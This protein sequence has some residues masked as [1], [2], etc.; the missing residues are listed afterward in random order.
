M[1]EVNE[2][3]HSITFLT[4]SRTQ[5][6]QQLPMYIAE[7]QGVDPTTD[8]LQYW[9][10]KERTVTISAWFQAF[11]WAAVFQPSSGAV[12]RLFSV[13]D[14]MFTNRQESC[15]ADYKSTSVMMSINERARYFDLIAREEM[16]AE[17]DMRD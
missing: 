10:R 16:D 1:S 7:S 2:S 12:E 8:I 3:I 14:W 13:L 6:I 11:T 17:N 5:L 4:P 9:Q 15:L